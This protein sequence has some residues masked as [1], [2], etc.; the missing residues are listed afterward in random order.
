M[1]ATGY[2]FLFL[3]NI[4]HATA[5]DEADMPSLPDFDGLFGAFFTL[6]GT[7]GISFVIPIALGIAKLSGI[8]IPMSFIIASIFAS[9]LYFPMAFLAVAMLDSVGA[10]NPLVVIPSILRVPGQYVVT[11]IMICIVFG[12]RILGDVFSGAAEGETYTTRSMSVLFISMGIQA[13]WSFVRIYLLT[14]TMRI[15]GNLY[16]TQRDKLGW[17]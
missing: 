16:L 1:M 12:V 17:I 2:L 4:I 9:L 6:L 5:A 14:V 10:A 11:V 7:I 8:E 13:V 15:L 3:Q